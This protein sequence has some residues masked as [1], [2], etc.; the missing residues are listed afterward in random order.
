[1]C[2]YNCAIFIINAIMFAVCLSV[3]FTVYCI[4]TYIVANGQKFLLR[5]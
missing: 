2:N 1:M 3:I 5:A 4:L